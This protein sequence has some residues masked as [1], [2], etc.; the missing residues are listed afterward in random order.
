M[1]TVDGNFLTRSLRWV[2]SFID[3][4][5]RLVLNLIFLFLVLVFVVA[6]VGPKAPE[7]QSHTAL[8]VSPIGIIVENYTQEP[9]DR[10]LSQWA[11]TDS[12]ET[13]LR[14]V[15][16]AIELAAD[17]PKITH[18]VINPDRILSAGM[19]VLQDIGAAV[20]RF[21]ASGKPVTALSDGMNQQQYYLAASA[22]QIILHPEGMVF[23][24]GFGRYRN[25]YKTLLDS[26]GVDVHLFRVG[27]YKSAAEPFIRDDMS[28]ETREANLSWLTSLWDSYLTEV[29]SQRGLSAAELHDTVE[30]FGRQLKENGGQTSMVALESGLVDLIANADEAIEYLIDNGVARVEG[31][32]RHVSVGEYL[33]SAAPRLSALSTK[34]KVAV[35]VAQGAITSGQPGP[36]ST[37][38][39]VTVGLLKQARHDSNIR[40][41]VLRVNSPGGQLFPSEQ[42][43]REVEITRASGKPVVVSM[44]DVAASGGYWIAMSANEIWANA[45]T[46]TGS[47]GVFGLVTTIPRG[48]DKI[49]VHT[50]GVGTTAMAGALRID[51]P[52]DRA[53]GELIQQIVE[54]GYSTFI[55]KVAEFR[56]MSVADVDEIARGRVWSGAQAQSHGLVDQLGGLSE[57]TRAAAALAGESDYDVRYLEPEMSPTERFLLDLSASSW[58]P[59]WSGSWLGDLGRLKD[60][61]GN[62]VSRDLA[63]LTQGSTGRPSVYAYCFCSW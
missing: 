38:S 14:E 49:G 47:I 4:T 46:I 6:L 35:I 53:V 2:W 36:E 3:G 41:V 19:G 39:Q 52:L 55:S 57:A 31:G 10:A 30:S 43:R 59:R 7:L 25:Y 29:G 15:I 22:D 1:A 20:A 16:Q 21:K 17:D 9:L 60:V 13:R 37:S 8:V 40:A 26:L 62:S 63:L 42:I 12:P 56:G 58:L 27:E 11:D 23:L 34:S 24:E 61:L 44:G 45:S 48:L 5:R 50:D 18:L 28:P 32:Y 54:N 51:R 33:S